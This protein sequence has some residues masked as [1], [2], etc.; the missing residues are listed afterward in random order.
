MNS[1]LLVVFLVGLSQG[2]TYLPVS[3]VFPWPTT[4]SGSVSVSADGSYT[5]EWASYPCRAGG[6]IGKSQFNALYGAC[7]SGQCSGS[8]DSTANANLASATDNNPYTGAWVPISH[9]E[10]RSWALFPFLNGS[11]SVI[12]IYVRGIWPINTQLFAIAANG[13]S[14]LV[15]TL[16]PQFNYQDLYFP[17]PSFPIAALK[18]KSVSIDGVMRGYCY[19]GVGDCKDLTVTEIAAQISPCLEQVAI[20]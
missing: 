7:A 8:C 17:G 18:L 20:I 13:A 19:S 2:Q 14:N 9:A 11:Q 4:S 6:W 10:G 3:T 5:T 12:Q 15:A 1:I 16:G